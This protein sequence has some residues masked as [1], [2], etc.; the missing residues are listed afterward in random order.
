MDAMPENTRATSEVAAFGTLFEVRKTGRGLKLGLQSVVDD[1]IDYATI[2]R[3]LFSCGW[4]SRHWWLDS[5]CSINLQGPKIDSVLV[6]KLSCRFQ[7][8]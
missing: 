1:H 3:V 4:I 2:V 8:G 5:P 6:F 7:Q